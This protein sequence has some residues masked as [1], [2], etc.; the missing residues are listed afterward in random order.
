MVRVPARGA[1]AFAATENPTT[2]F[3]MPL[4]P[5][6]MVTKPALLTAVHPQPDVVLTFTVPDPPV[7]GKFW[8]LE[9]SAKLHATPGVTCN[10]NGVVS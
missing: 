8:L 3:P 9:D 6:V 10:V 2:P 1:P 5:E 7:A 4:A